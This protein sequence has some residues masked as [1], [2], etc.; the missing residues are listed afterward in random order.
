MLYFDLISTPETLGEIFMIHTS[1]LLIRQFTEQD[2]KSLFEYLSNPS[3]Y[4]YEPGEPISLEAAREIAKKRSQNNDFWAVI[5]NNTGEL[6]G[7]IFFKQTEPA[8]FLTWELGYIFNP[9]FQ[10]K[11]YATESS[12][13]LIPYGFKHWGIHKVVANCN[14]ENIASWRVLE[15]IGMARE[16]L[17]RK[18]VYFKRDDDGNPK[19]TDTLTYGILKDDIEPSMEK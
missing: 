18:N 5:L 3:I 15:K 6:V 2:Y 8:E 16:G 9:V 17:I 1:R 13:A 4:I 7:H 14:P 10:N 11:G 12:N 19:W